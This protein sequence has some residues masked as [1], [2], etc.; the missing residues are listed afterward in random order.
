MWYLTWCAD[1][2]LNTSEKPIKLAS[3]FVIN[4]RRWVQL[5]TLSSL[6]PPLD[7]WWIERFSRNGSV[8][9]HHHSLINQKAIVVIVGKSWKCLIWSVH[10]LK[11]GTTTWRESQKGGSVQVS[12]FVCKL[13]L[14][15]R[16]TC[17]AGVFVG[18]LTLL[19]TCDCDWNNFCRK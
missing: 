16:K 3:D 11:P 1:Y 4:S 13:M 8:A 18:T 12:R 14:I 6:I 2:M 9:Q 17:V 5:I 10:L 15:G 19:V 7:F